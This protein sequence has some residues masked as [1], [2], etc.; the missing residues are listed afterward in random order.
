LNFTA[1]QFEVVTGMDKDAW[2]EELSLHDALFEQLNLRL[3]QVLLDTRKE[4]GAKLG[5]KL[6]A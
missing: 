5:E 4:M 1:E 2:K 6:T 3:P